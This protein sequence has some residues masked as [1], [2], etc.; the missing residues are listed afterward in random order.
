[1]PRNP[2]FSG[3]GIPPPA[4]K[5][6]RRKEIP[7][8]NVL[9]P[10]C[11][12]VEVV[13]LETG[14][15]K[16][17]V[18]WEKEAGPAHVFFSTVQQVLNNHERVIERFLGTQIPLAADKLLHL[19]GEGQRMT[20][21][22]RRLTNLA[23]RYLMPLRSEDSGA[24]KKEIGDIAFTI[25]RVTN[26]Y[27]RRAQA[28]LESALAT[29]QRPGQVDRVL[30]ANMAVLKR[31]EESLLIVQGTLARFRR[32]SRKRDTWEGTIE[33][34]FRELASALLA[35]EKEGLTEYQ[36]EQIARQISG[37]GYGSWLRLNGINGPEYARRIQ[38]PQVQNLA[39][40]GD[41]LRGGEE[42]RAKRVLREAIF[43]LERVVQEKRTREQGEV[44][45]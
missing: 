11:H 22:S 12:G 3:Q 16:Y 5:R 17:H 41:F 8:F 42:R 24:L 20:D 19:E 39:R 29:P 33:R 30:E 34:S 27:K 14:E 38:T 45:K 44:E 4:E 26:E 2:E 18:T 10:I 40:F 31:N 43:K 36:K 15:T 7:R 35:L 23:G 28:S 37:R 9:E 32:V 1:M 25:G 21:L 6:F 13:Q